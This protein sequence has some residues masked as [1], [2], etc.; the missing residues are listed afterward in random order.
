MSEADKEDTTI[1]LAE[2]TSG[3]LIRVTDTYEIC[4]QD[5]R[6]SFDGGT[7]IWVMTSKGTRLA[8]LVKRVIE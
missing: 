1:R 8:R 5:A 2:P 3:Q 6:S 7:C 4:E